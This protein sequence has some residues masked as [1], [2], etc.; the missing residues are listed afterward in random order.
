VKGNYG[1]AFMKGVLTLTPL[2]LR[3][4]TIQ[5]MLFPSPRLLIGFSTFSGCNSS[6]VLGYSS[7]SMPTS[8]LIQLPF[9]S[10]PGSS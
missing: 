9:S 5:S 10:N 3:R 8:P 6:A 7:F 4:M 1:N 2:P